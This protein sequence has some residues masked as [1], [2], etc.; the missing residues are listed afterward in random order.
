MNKVGLKASDIIAVVDTR[1]QTPLDLSPFRVVRKGLTTGDYSI[2]HL[3]KEISIERKSLPDLLGSIGRDRDRFDAE[4]KRLLAYPSRMLLIE[5]TIDEIE[6]GQWRSKLKPSHVL[7]A[8]AGFQEMGIPVC[9][10]GDHLRASRFAFNH[11]RLAALRRWGELRAFFN[12][13]NSHLVR[14]DEKKKDPRRSPG[15]PR[16]D[17]GGDGVDGRMESRSC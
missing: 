8:L 3:E 5:S 4:M 9:L 14:T 16:G 7:G 10:A 13:T 15:L 12:E 2:L 6:K 17:E 11:L 1:E